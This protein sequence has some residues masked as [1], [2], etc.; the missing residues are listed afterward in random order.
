MRLYYRKA[1]FYNDKSKIFFLIINS[2]KRYGKQHLKDMGKRQ[3]NVFKRFGKRC[4][5]F[6][7]VPYMTTDIYSYFKNMIAFSKINFLDKKNEKTG[8][9]NT[10]N[11]VRSEV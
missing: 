11:I 3:N 5:R 7:S 8:P 4:E 6:H 2:P 10:Y 9:Y 1:V